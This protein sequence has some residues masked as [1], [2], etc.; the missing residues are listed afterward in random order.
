MKMPIFVKTPIID[1]SA[2]YIE[3]PA[4]LVPAGFSSTR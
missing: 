4:G 3:K 2:D 1:E